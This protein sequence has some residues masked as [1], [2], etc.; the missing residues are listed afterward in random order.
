MYTYPIDYDLYSNDEI[1]ELVKF[2]ALIEDANEHRSK[3]TR[4]QLVAAY[5][6]YSRIVNS[7]SLEKEQDKKFEKASGYSIYQTMKNFK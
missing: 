2:F 3:V 6:Q 1:V 4:E 7:K 5:K